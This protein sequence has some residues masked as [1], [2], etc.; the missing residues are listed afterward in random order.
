MAPGI[1]VCDVEMYTP[2]AIVLGLNH[3]A[4]VNQALAA[5]EWPGERALGHRIHT[6]EMH[7]PEGQSWATVVGVVENV[8]NYD[9][10]SAPGP[11]L[12]IPRAENP[13]GLARLVVEAGGDP[14]LL[15]RAARKK[16]K[17]Q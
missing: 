7:S 14:A 2:P 1:C 11:D 6:G 17:S 13:S 5:R 15:K 12:Y 8:H 4:I 3:V 16:L 9:L 10:V